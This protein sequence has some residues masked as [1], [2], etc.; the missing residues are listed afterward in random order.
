MEYTTA[1]KISYRRL[2]LLLKNHC[3]IDKYL[4]C[5]YYRHM[6]KMSNYMTIQHVANELGVS[7]KTLRRWE[8]KG[9]FVPE[10]QATTNIRIYH[11]WPVGYWKRML[12]LDRS[13]KQHLKRLDGLR[14]ELD[15]HMTEQDYIPGKKLKIIDGESF[16]KAYEDIS[17]W[18][19]EFK[20]LLDELLKYPQSMRVAARE[21]NETERK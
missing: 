19:E 8:E 18:D 6:N 20:R 9:Y 13:I 17:Q 5:L 7:T 1:N 14:K 3:T 16:N 15:K 11:T 10:R 12:E 21:I 2:M 4:F